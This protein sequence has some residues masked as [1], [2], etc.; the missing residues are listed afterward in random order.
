[1]GNRPPEGEG[2]LHQ[3]TLGEPLM[4]LNLIEQRLSI[5]IK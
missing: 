4:F 1:M 5:K 2:G 3:G